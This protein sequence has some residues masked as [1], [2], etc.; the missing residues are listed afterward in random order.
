MS[1]NS[2]KVRQNAE[3]AS[4]SLNCLTKISVGVRTVGRCNATSLASADA[5]AQTAMS[6]PSARLEATGSG[7]TRRARAFA[8]MNAVAVPAGYSVHALASKFFD[9]SE[10]LFGQQVMRHWYDVIK[11]G[12]I[13]F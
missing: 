7:T 13:A 5:S 2:L 11:S 4:K 9:F 1:G 3:V 10:E 6:E 8:E 12:S